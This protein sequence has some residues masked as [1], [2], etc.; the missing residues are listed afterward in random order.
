MLSYGPW[1]L[2]FLNS[3][4][5]PGENGGRTDRSRPDS[6]TSSTRRWRRWM[7]VLTA[8]LRRAKLRRAREETLETLET[9]IKRILM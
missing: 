3:F 6:R 8:W 9:V 1:V 7:L 4:I 2:W 5:A